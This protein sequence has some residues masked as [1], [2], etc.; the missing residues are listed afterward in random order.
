MTQF[1]RWIPFNLGDQRATAGFH[2]GERGLG[3]RAVSPH[4]CAHSVRESHPGGSVRQ[5]GSIHGYACSGTG[6]IAGVDD[7]PRAH[8]REIITGTGRAISLRI[9]AN[10]LEEP[11]G[12]RVAALLQVAI[13]E[14]GGVVAVP[15]A[16]D[17][18][19]DLVGGYHV[20]PHSHRHKDM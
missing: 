18:P 10:V 15:S 19:C 17:L 4:R 2:D 14:P 5:A 6:P 16:G 1:D 7:V 9:L 11:Q 3:S 13:L 8:S 12:V 20:L